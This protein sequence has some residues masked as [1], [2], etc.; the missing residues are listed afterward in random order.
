MLADALLEAGFSQDEVDAGIRGM[1]V[2]LIGSGNEVITKGSDVKE[3]VLPTEDLPVMG[4]YP[5][6][7]YK[8]GEMPHDLGAMLEEEFDLS[9]PQGRALLAKLFD[10]GAKGRQ[11]R[12]MLFAF[13]ET[14]SSG[15][16]QLGGG[17]EHRNI[18]VEETGTYVRRR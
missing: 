11:P 1:A 18:K 14:H 7:N 16:L 12:D 17:W 9:T 2:A 10:T 13:L 8:E 6:G 4:K 15:L 5:T 3:V